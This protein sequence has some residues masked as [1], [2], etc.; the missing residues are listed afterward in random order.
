MWSKN[1]FGTLVVAFA[2]T[3]GIISDLFI[4]LDQLIK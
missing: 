1:D 3:K 4:I 2:P